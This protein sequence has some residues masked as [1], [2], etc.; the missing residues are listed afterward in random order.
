[1][2][3][4]S[5]APKTPAQAMTVAQRPQSA[6]AVVDAEKPVTYL[7]FASNV[8]VRLTP[9]MVIDFLCIP[10]R[11]GTKCNIA[12]A[13][14]YM[15]MCEAR[16]L[17]PWEGDAFLQGYEGDGGIKF[18]LIT[19]HQAFLKRAE[20]SEHYDG[21]QS[22]VV[23]M[24]KEGDGTEIE[25]EGDIFNRNRYTLVGGWCKAYRKDRRFPEYKRLDLD[26]FST[27]YSRWKKDPAGMIV[28][29]A[30]ADA[31]RSAFPTVIGGLYLAEELGLE[32][33]NVTPPP[34][35][36]APSFI[37][38]PQPEPEPP[39]ANV[40]PLPEDEPEPEPPKREPP[41][42]ATPQVDATEG[43]DTDG[44]LS[45]IQQLMKKD[46]VSEDQVI[47]HLRNTKLATQKHTEIKHLSDSKLRTL[48]NAWTRELD[49]IKAIQV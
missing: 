29:C 48:A 27:G 11:N 35:I 28:K 9:R 45:L 20:V 12:D 32:E 31:L 46:G 39:P 40:A 4:Q 42:P 15:K 22:G 43:L 26:T 47:G 8:E 10:T 3:N 34:K 30:E 44:V 2:T 13:V 19:A 5:T 41:P 33:K 36:E 7:A 17:N 23:V 25:L 18:N 49:A 14:K 38:Q 6:V 1:M 21:K 24:V 16:R 37:T